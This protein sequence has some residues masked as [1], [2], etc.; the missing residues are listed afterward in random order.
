ML[1]NR[2]T[3][4]RFWSLRKQREGS[5]MGGFSS[6]QGAPQGA[7]R[8]H[9]GAINPPPP[10][11]RSSAAIRKTTKTIKRARRLTETPK[12]T[13]MVKAE[14]PPQNRREKPLQEKEQSDQ[15]PVMSKSHGDPSDEN[16]VKQFPLIV[17]H[18]HV[19][20]DM[21]TPPASVFAHLWISGNASFWMR[22]LTASCL[23]LRAGS[24]TTSVGMH[25]IVG[26]LNVITALEDLQ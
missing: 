20:I 7:K 16:T 26:P 12:N 8:S 14:T 19:L 9:Q 24:T 23:L 10:K 5:T 22:I 18:S 4:I 15:K 11:T 1:S 21:A 6:H 17:V 2:S 13:K 25:R 3:M